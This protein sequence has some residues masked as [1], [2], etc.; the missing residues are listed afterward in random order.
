MTGEA[1]YPG[2][3]ALG[4][5]HIP[6]LLAVC[7][8]LARHGSAPANLRLNQSYRRTHAHVHT[9]THSITSPPRAS[10]ATASR[11]RTDHICLD[12]VLSAA[13]PLLRNPK[14]NLCCNSNTNMEVK[15]SRRCVFYL[16]FCAFISKILTFRIFCTFA[17]RQRSPSPC[18]D[19]S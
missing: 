5:A 1:E 3:D 12:C 8:P 6:N 15:K 17:S 9:H 14:E 7:S 13:V 11:A 16:C 10:I 18:I 4:T 19:F 2:T